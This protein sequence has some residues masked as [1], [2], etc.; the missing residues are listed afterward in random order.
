MQLILKELKQYKK[1]ILLLFLLVLGFSFC[2]ISVPGLIRNLIDISIPNKDYVSAVI[3]SGF[4]FLL[5]VFQLIFGVYI[6]KT[7]SNIVTSISARLR[8]KMFNKVINLS[9]QQI[10]KFSISS[11]I[12]RTCADI[13]Q[14]QSFLSVGLNI[15]FMAP[16]MCIIG[17]FGA[18]SVSS[19][20]SS[21][22]IFTLP[23]MCVVF[24][25]IGRA[26]IPLT[27]Q[28][29]I[30]LDNINRVIREQLSGSRVIRAFGTKNFEKQ[31]FDIV[32]REYFR[33]N[34]K[35]LY[36]IGLFN[37]FV[38]VVF[39]VTTCCVFL[40]AIFFINNQGIG[41]T[42]GQIVTV[43]S[44]ITSIVA[45]VIYSII[46]I[47]YLPRT[48]TCSK[49][50]EEVL[51]AKDLIESPNSEIKIQ[52]DDKASVEFK[53]VSFTY[54]GAKKSAVANLNFKLN[55][56]QTLAIIGG[57][58]TG[59]TTIIN[60]IPRLYDCT[61]GEVLVDGVNVKDY[62]LNDLREKIGFVPQSACLFK[63]TIYSNIEFG[64]TNIS[65]QKA[66][67]ALKCAQAY[68]FVSST[69]KDI[70][71]EV[72]QSGT[73]FS[74]GQKQRLCIARAI[75][76][77][78]KIYVFDDSFSALD[79]KTDKSIRQSLKKMTKDACTIIVA[80]RV[81]T[82]IDADQIIVI[83][84]GNPVGIGTHDELVS[85]CSTYREIVESQMG[86]AEAV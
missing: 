13:V 16:L 1:Q 73:N 53:N 32:N 72:S 84:N 83:D 57:T 20:I 50:V 63:G 75:A 27:N 42:S 18:I 15:I 56:G 80:Q 59:K 81:S 78:R 67:E 61:K 41:F 8:S 85:N 21:I 24:I 37:P 66:I 58:G 49:R 65:E 69:D 52:D 62:K 77:K 36:L 46:I 76:N 19:N 10:D 39:A 3:I 54:P 22:L 38:N 30:K 34:K 11:M 71:A 12:T 44:Y 28:I 82:I 86:T 79:F 17:T 26:T 33:L 23:V 7:S 70:Y 40:S 51:N 14:I 68:D 48:I 25:L 2:F 5:I 9:S 74:G 31:R 45:S 4:M 43:I 29:Q 60:M 35:M 47:L 6:S 55:A 64:S